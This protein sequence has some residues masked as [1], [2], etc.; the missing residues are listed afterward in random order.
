MR[1]S[2]SHFAVASLAAVSLGLVALQIWLMALGAAGLALTAAGA[3]L[4][5]RRRTPGL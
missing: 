3:F 2:L 5:M 4:S 1:V